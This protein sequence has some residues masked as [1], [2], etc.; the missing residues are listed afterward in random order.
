MTSAAVAGGGL[1]EGAAPEA[2]VTDS[3]FSL[4]REDL[5]RLARGTAEA[6]KG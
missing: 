5:L 2:A 4:P 6:S 1:Q 3:G